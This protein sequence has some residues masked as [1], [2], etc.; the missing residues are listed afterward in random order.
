MGLTE[1]QGT[2]VFFVPDGT[3]LTTVFE[4]N[5]AITA[6]SAKEVGCIQNIGSLASTRSVQT[7]SCLDK[8]TI[9]KSLGSLSLGNISVGTLFDAKDTAGQADL[10]AMYIDNS[11]RIGIVVLNDGI[12]TDTAGAAPVL[13]NPTY[14]TFGAG[15]SGQDVSVQKDNAVMITST[16]EFTTNITEFSAT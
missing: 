15:V 4:I 8:D 12:Y 2:R 11:R 6:V 16:V 10:K 1:S 7:Y 9:Q 13:S 3:A 14:F 5:A